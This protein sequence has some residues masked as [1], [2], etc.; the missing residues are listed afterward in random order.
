MSR[1]GGVPV[2]NTSRFGGVAVETKQPTFKVGDNAKAINEVLDEGPFP[3]KG[4][5]AVLMGLAHGASDTVRGFKQIFGDDQTQKKLKAEEDLVQE[6]Y[7]QHPVA[8]RAG[9]VTGFIA[10]P[11]NLAM[12][13]AGGVA[14][15]GAVKGSKALSALAK[16]TPRFAKTMVGGASVGG[17]SAGTTYIDPEAG[18][19]REEVV[20]MG[21]AGGA[22]LAPVIDKGVRSYLK[23]KGNKAKVA[24]SN[25]VDDYES[26]YDLNLIQHK[27]NK[28]KAHSATQKQLGFSWGAARKM[29]SNADR[30][31][32]TLAKN[33]QEAKEIL[34]QKPNIYGLST[35]DE[36]KAI[37][38][39]TMSIDE[40][41]L[42]VK[43]IKPSI[44]KKTV[45]KSQQRQKTK[46]KKHV[47]NA[48]DYALGSTMTR[49]RN[50]SPAVAKHLQVFEKFV[51]K[52]SNDWINEGGKFFDAMDEFKKYV[53]PRDF[54]RFY[55]KLLTDSDEA[56]KWVAQK[57]FGKSVVKEYPT[58]R[59]ILDDIYEM[60]GELEGV[61]GFRKGFFPRVPSKDPAKLGLIANDP[62]NKVLMKQLRMKGKADDAEAWA[63]ALDSYAQVPKEAEFAKGSTLGRKRRHQIVKTD[64][65]EAYVDPRAAFDSYIE[66]TTHTI[67][68]RNF[69]TGIG[70]PDHK[71][72]ALGEV[73]NEDTLIDV[74]GKSGI[75]GDDA[76][77]LAQLLQAR[78]GP[79][80]Q[81]MGVL[82]SGMKDIS[83]ITLLG[84]IHSTLTQV[85]DIY[86]S[87]YKNGVLNAIRGGFRNF[88][89]KGLSKEDVLGLRDHIA[90]FASTSPTKKVADK[91]LTATGFRAVDRFGKQTFMNSSLLKNQQLA[92]NPDKFAKKWGEFF[93]NETEAL[94]KELLSY[95]NPD[96][97][98][99]RIGLMLWDD[100]SKVQPISLS[101]MPEAYL[102]MNNGRLLYA[103]NSFTLKQLDIVRNNV[104]NNLRRG[105]Y[106]EAAKQLAA[107]G[108]FFTGASIP[109]DMMK[110]H[111]AGREPRGLGHL[112][113]EGALKAIGL[114]KYTLD[115]LDK[116]DGLTSAIAGMVSASIAP[117]ATLYHGLANDKPEQLYE[118]I[119]GVGR[120]L[121]FRSREEDLFGDLELD[122][123]FED[124][125]K[126]GLFSGSVR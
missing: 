74:V 106:A 32:P 1:F 46:K 42:W 45:S 109:V 79:G 51:S 34:V 91:V 103:L 100:L 20:G 76:L 26:L 10:D 5:N 115:K 65:A 105:N 125:D 80:E 89:G 44:Q 53:S 58:I 104:Y 62:E 108:V 75:K 22:I 19:T 96:D 14:V 48:L 95:K 29:A 94:R 6:V 12:V 101:E 83:H 33:P 81:S 4:A 17:L 120:T 71:V 121:K 85:Q 93:E 119:P 112:A 92:K 54:N 47:R 9:Q 110:D 99:D 113:G 57:P 25:M 114:N 2:T 102:R 126:E 69:F 82:A 67:G 118:F 21:T 77:E 27:G 66:K 63:K 43:S 117:F 30:E 13:G 84:D 72:S 59:K 3:W 40:S 55:A 39:G 88:T 15:K 70:D 52:K 37:R 35:E 36:I 64:Q 68:R 38:E 86:S 7:K 111:L 73:L 31:V 97:V 49:V 8:G 98:T 11:A 28:R 16:A 23:Y 50:I 60:G 123:D 87:M 124:L 56:M 78:F 61:V 90:D 24:Q 41:D 116:P 107:Y 122:L 18:L